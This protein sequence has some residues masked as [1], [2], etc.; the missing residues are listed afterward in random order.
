MMAD[1]E[2]LYAANPIDGTSAANDAGFNIRPCVERLRNGIAAREHKNTP[3]V[4]VANT[5]SHSP[6]VIIS[7]VR[8]GA[9]PALFTSTSTPPYTESIFANAASTADASETSHSKGNT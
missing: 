7:M 8:S 9:T 1:L 6:P 4:F 2:A 5:P 3:R